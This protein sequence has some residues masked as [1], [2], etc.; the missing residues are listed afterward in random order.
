MLVE[1][2]A[3]GMTG[4]MAEEVGRPTEMLSEG[5]FGKIAEGTVVVLTEMLSEG[6][7]GEIVEGLVETLAEGLSEG[8]VQGQAE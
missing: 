5:K 2:L 1:G 7:I 6:R 3:D 4:K 8:L